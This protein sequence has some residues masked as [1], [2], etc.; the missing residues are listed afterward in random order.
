MHV[1]MLP[2]CRA[3]E[4]LNTW[5]MGHITTL[6]RDSTWGTCSTGC[7]LLS[8]LALL[9]CLSDGLHLTCKCVVLW[10]A[11]VHFGPRA[12]VLNVL[13]LHE[14][15]VVVRLRF[16][17]ERR[18]QLSQVTLN[19]DVARWILVE[20]VTVIACSGAY[21]LPCVVVVK[22]LDSVSRFVLLLLTDCFQSTCA[23]VLRWFTSL[24]DTCCVRVETVCL[25]NLLG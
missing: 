4:H 22:E 3:F 9:Q 23:H 8:L 14:E 15:L 5:V 24:G 6:R 25:V 12:I 18:L 1:N 2:K 19:C 13:T 10:R 17:I 7:H 11:I 21:L 16:S 20:K